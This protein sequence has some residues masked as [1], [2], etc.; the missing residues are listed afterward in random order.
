MVSETRVA[1]RGDIDKIEI[2][3]LSK[4]QLSENI[5]NYNKGKDKMENVKEFSKQEKTK[6][7]KDKIPRRNL[8]I[9]G[10]VQREHK[11]R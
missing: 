8:R 11:L 9:G 7:G 6:K 5:S 2:S 3:F 4:C 1:V 10:T